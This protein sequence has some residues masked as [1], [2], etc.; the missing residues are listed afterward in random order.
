MWNA[1]EPSLLNGHNAEYIKLNNCSPSSVMVT[2]Q[3]DWKIREPDKKKPKQINRQTNIQLSLC[4]FLIKVASNFSV[5]WHYMYVNN[6][7]YWKKHI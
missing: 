1:K 2:P 6:K 4:E 5:I 3:Y 7:F